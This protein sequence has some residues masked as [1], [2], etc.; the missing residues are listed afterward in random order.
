MPDVNTDWYKEV[1][2]PANIQNHSLNVLGGSERASYS[3]GM[4]YH[5]E[6]GIMNMENDY[7][8]YNVRSKIDYKANDWLTIGGNII[9]SNSINNEPQEGAWHTTYFAVP[10]MP[11][12]DDL[13][14]DADPINFAS[15]EHLGYRGGKNPFTAMT[16]SE[17]RLKKINMLTNFYMKFDIIPKKYFQ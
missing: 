8:R 12:Y 1:L 9:L 5:A 15:A 6:E 10:V 2:R 14:V 16:F 3:V 13:N 4:N 11:V 7:T 17:N